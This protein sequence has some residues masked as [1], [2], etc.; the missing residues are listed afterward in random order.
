MW[1]TI[2]ELAR[3]G[4]EMLRVD[5]IAVVA[6]V[7]KTTIYRRWP[8]K[9]D[10]VAAALRASGRDLSVM[11]NTGSARGDLLAMLAAQ[12]EKYKRTEMRCLSR[13]FLGEISSPELVRLVRSLRAEYR[14]RWTEVVRRGIARGDLPA[15]TQVE[16][17]VDLISSTS[18]MR[19]IRNDGPLDPGAREAMVDLVLAGAVAASAR[20]PRPGKRHDRAAAHSGPTRPTSLPAVRRRARSGS[21]ANAT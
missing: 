1:A 7:N 5:D 4:Y 9:G 10:L 12:A 19:L 11:P 16:I 17:V 13:V 21:K 2:T 3:T 14:E 18:S 6:K 15:G 20:T 8:T